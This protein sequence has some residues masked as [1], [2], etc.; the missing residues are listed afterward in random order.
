MKKR[1]IFL[2]LFLVLWMPLSVF[3]VDFDTYSQNIIFYN[4]NDEM[5]LYEKNSDEKVSIASMTKIM[6]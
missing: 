4:L 1:G 6:N 3:G 5:V 2:I